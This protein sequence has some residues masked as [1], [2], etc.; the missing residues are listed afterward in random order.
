MFF[1]DHQGVS[2]QLSLHP[3]HLNPDKEGNLPPSALIP[4]CSYQGDS[5]LLGHKLDKLG[6]LTTCDKF[7]PGILDGQLCYSIDVAA[8][9][10]QKTRPGKKNG[11]FLLLDPNPY[12]VEKKRDENSRLDEESFKVYIHTLAQY[13]TYGPGSYGLSTLKKITG[14][15]GFKQLPD[16]QKKCLVHNREECQTQK[17]L[18]QVKRECNC[19]PWTLMTEH[20]KNQVSTMPFKPISFLILISYYLFSYRAGACLL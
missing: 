12:L 9:G 5:S 4:F 16:H 19:V 7:K 20:N 18:D 15:T 17:Y 6:N 1:S 10:K 11:L 14:T 8:L 2:Q 3:V 13:S